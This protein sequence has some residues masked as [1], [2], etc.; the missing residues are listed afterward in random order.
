MFI[1]LSSFSVLRSSRRVRS[2]A[3]H[4]LLGEEN[5]KKRGSFRER[6]LSTGEVDRC[7]M[8]ETA[9]LDRVFL[10]TQKDWIFLGK[11]NFGYKFD[12]L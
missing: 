5:P 9:E 6:P 12:S 4:F 11:F 3:K 10:Y 1:P 2:R 8:G 7:L